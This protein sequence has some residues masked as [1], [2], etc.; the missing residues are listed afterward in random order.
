MVRHF[1]LKKV[2][3]VKLKIPWL[4]I[5]LLVLLISFL[6]LIFFFTDNL[7]FSLFPHYLYEDRLSRLNLRYNRNLWSIINFAFFKFLEGV[8]IPESHIPFWKEIIM[9]VWRNFFLNQKFLIRKKKT[10]FSLNLILSLPLYI[11][12][13][14]RKNSL[15]LFCPLHLTIIT[16]F[17][18]CLIFFFH[19][20]L[21]TLEF[22][23][24]IKNKISLTIS[25]N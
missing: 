6:W 14:I 13:W 23:F 18:I 2:L 19:L 11:F 22:W 16:L 25:L 15:Y 1:F 5:Y 8:F 7:V 12:F 17:E 24:G 21:P 10:H 3:F 20:L 9:F 4:F